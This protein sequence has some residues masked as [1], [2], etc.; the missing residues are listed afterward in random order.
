[1]RILQEKLSQIRVSELKMYPGTSFYDMYLLKM[2]LTE[3]LAIR[4]NHITQIN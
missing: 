2:S 1:M 3:G 4:I